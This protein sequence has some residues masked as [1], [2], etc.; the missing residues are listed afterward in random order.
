MLRGTQGKV[1]TA[2]LRASPA[3]VKRAARALEFIDTAV[4]PPYAAHLASRVGKPALLLYGQLLPGP[5][6]GSG[7][8]KIGLTL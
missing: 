2:G 7:F 8:A 6:D 1:A 4:V 5:P 3:R